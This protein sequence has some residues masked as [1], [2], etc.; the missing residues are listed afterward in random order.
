MCS[1]IYGWNI[2]TGAISFQINRHSDSITDFI[3]VDHLNI[4]ITCAMDKRIVMWSSTSRRVKGILLGHQRGV[5]A[6]S[7]Y[8]NLLLSAGFECDG[9]LWDLNG[10]DN[11]AVLKGHRH[12]IVAVKLMC[13]AAQAEKDHRAITVDES[14]EF[15]LW[16]IYLHEGGGNDTKV[17]FAPPILLDLT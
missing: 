2:D 9:L 10:K 4:F 16:N 13:E 17:G 12:P 7:V 1:G 3:A 15:R 6:L 5:R 11:I 14:G 8:E